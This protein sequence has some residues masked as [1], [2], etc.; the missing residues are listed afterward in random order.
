MP[1]LPPSAAIANE[2]NKIIKVYNAFFISYPFLIF[3]NNY[4]IL[5]HACPATS[6]GVNSG[7][8]LLKTQ[9]DSG[10]SAGM[11]INTKLKEC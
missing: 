7:R 4:T 10:T 5:C 1:T 9:G 8:H 3:L 2:K 11:T 6:A